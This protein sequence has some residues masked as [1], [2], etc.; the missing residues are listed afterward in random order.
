M[1]LTIHNFFFSPTDSS[2]RIGETI[3]KNLAKALNCPYG[4]LPL[5]RGVNYAFG[6]G[7]VMVFAFPVY[8]GRVPPLIV[9]WLKKK[10]EAP[11][12][13]AIPVA[14]YGNRAFDD[15]PLE[16]ADILTG[17]GAEVVAAVAAIAQH[18]FDPAIAAGRPDE[19][20]DKILSDFAARIAGVLRSGEPRKPVIPG[21]RPY[22]EISPTPPITPLT[23]DACNYCGICAEKCPAG[24]IDPEDEH[25]VKPGCILCA[26]C[27]KYCPRNAKSLPPAFLEKVRA[28]LAK[29]AVK[30]KDPELF[31]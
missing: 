30:R 23:G 22:K 20:D 14:V 21:S 29:V 17:L 24:V 19:E 7:D 13:K 16:A 28:M 15:A 31:L 6:D 11:G 12:A 4:P 10:V 18:T 25:I 26:A 2:R 3:G 5:V 9:D 1:P 8:G 27:V